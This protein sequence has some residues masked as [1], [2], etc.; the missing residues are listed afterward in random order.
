ME[1]LSYMRSVVDGNVVKRR[2]TVN[3]TT[4][5]HVGEEGMQLH[6]FL[7]FTA[8]RIECPASRFCSLFSEGT[9]FVTGSVW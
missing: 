4:L 3:T 2:I 6:A 7:S 5:K 9:G 1:P 8:D